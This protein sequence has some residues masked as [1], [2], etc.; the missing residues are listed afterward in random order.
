MRV[1]DLLNWSANHLKNHGVDNPRLEAELLLGYCMGME[2][3]KLYI[4]LNDS[5]DGDIIERF[6]T[7]LE[8]RKKGEPLQYILGQK[9][10]WSINI[11]LN[12]KVFIPR[13]ETE[14]LVEEA[15]L[16]SQKAQDRRNL[17]ILEIGTGSGAIVIALAKE[18]RNVSL[19]ATDISWDAISLAKENAMLAGV[20]EKILFIKCDL[21]EAI[22]P[23]DGGY[24]D[25]I[26]SNPPYIKRS[27]IQ[28]LQKE[29]RDYEPIQAIDG[30]E[31]G[32]DFYR[33]IIGQSSLYLRDGGWL[34]LEMG[35][36]QAGPI[37]DLIKDNKFFKKIDIIKDLSGIERVLK[38]KKKDRV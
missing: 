33:R 23:L 31:D 1:V 36:G 25:M 12:S 6:Y 18:L 3:E 5:I 17:K 21:F 14:L 38:I 2:R 9:E 16:I 4:H 19:I 37:M 28:R 26:I 27:D 24:F 11:K 10:F 15:L 7:K 20:G 29:V 30:G 32:L 8:R 35:H 22:R 34:L 13:P